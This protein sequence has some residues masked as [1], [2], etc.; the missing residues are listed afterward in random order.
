MKER[1]KISA[2]LSNTMAAYSSLSMMQQ[3]SCKPFHHQL[4][5][6]IQNLSLTNYIASTIF[7]LLPVAKEQNEKFLSCPASKQN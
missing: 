3:I 2:L 5:Q 4:K 6:R 7:A 1:S